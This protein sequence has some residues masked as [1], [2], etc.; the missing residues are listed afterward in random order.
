M[1]RI[2]ELAVLGI[3]GLSLFVVA[4]LGFARMSGTPLSKV[5]VVGPMFTD[6]QAEDSAATTES[7]AEPGAATQMYTTPRQVI[8]ANTALLSAYA[9]ESPFSAAELQTLS[10]ELKT[11][12]LK[13][14]A[15]LE[16]LDERERGLADR[17]ELMLHQFQTL[18]ELK[19]ELKR[20]EAEL[21]L[22][23]SE[24]M[25]DEDKAA[26]GPV[27][28]GLDSVAKLFAEGKADGLASRLIQYPAAEAAEILSHL[29]DDRAA[30]LLN[31][32]P[33]DK[34]KSYVAAYSARAA[35]K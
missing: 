21:T 11:A 30:E 34:W 2:I 14:E 31:A 17:E 4:F 3:G 27:T 23:S 7:T 24:V 15:R 20:F 12:K 33:A 8:E 32:L 16:S 6:D 35:S 22:R 13:Y 1:N 19:Q 25:R 18:D 28:P 10:V 26:L 29:S 5:A 9:L